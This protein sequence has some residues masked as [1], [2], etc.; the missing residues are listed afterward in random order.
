MDS[1][2]KFLNKGIKE[3]SDVDADGRM[4]TKNEVLSEMSGYL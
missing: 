1:G 4:K 3:G 2:R